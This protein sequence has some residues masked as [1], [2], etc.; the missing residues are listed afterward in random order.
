MWDKAYDF[1]KVSFEK[2]SDIL[3]TNIVFGGLL[4]KIE[5]KTGIPGSFIIT[6]F[7]ICLI[8][9]FLLGTGPSV[10]CYSAVVLYPAYQSF[11]SLEEDNK[12][13]SY[14]WIK[15]WIVFA[16]FHAVEHLGDRFMWWLPGYMLLKFIFLLWCFAPVPNN[17]SVIIYENYIRTLFLR[18]VETLDRVTDMVTT[19]IHKIVTKRF[20][21]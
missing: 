9:L 1:V 2:I 5:E 15:Y 12:E 6:G 16:A 19:L 11:K 4:N 17:G 7:T 14:E 20:S 18:N 13:K 10:L 3:S 21:E 8:L